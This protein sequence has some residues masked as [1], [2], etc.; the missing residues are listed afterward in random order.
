MN[1]HVIWS[2]V[3]QEGASLKNSR[4]GS[5]VSD[6][7]LGDGDYMNGM[8]HHQSVRFI[9]CLPQ[10]KFQFLLNIDMVS[11]VVPLFASIK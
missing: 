11:Y 7:D 2:R 8:I 6:L 9:F 4:K 1:G 5:Y 10:S 3:K